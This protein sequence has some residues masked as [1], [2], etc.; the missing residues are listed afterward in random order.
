M[1]GGASR[2]RTGDLLHAMQA[3]S[4]LSYSPNKLLNILISQASQILYIF[5]YLTKDRECKIELRW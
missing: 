3:L 5:I 2:D 1:D 4:Q